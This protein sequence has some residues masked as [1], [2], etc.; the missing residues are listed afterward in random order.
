MIR[1]G[2]AGVPINCNSGSTLDGIR[3]CKELGLNAMELE[4]VHGVRMKDEKAKEAKKISEELDI[5]LSSHAPYYINCCTTD[6]RKR[7]NSFRHIFS[8][9]KTTYLAGGKITVFHPG[10]Y[11]KLTKEEAYENAKKLLQE[12]E[13]KCKQ[14]NVKIRLGAETVGKKSAFGGLE[15][16]VRLSQDIEM[17][18]VV[19]DFSHLVARG[20]YKLENEDDYRKVFEYVERELPGYG[21]RIHA[22]FSEINFTEKGERNHLILG[23]NNTPPFK[24]LMK[25]L[26]EGG[27]S[28]TIICETP[29]IDEDALL[30]KGEYEKIVNRLS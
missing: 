17:V 25:V 18:D 5:S 28:G 27:Y 7:A 9:A 19:I 10:F 21:K 2:P 16:N 26:A 22:H 23:S 29:K 24:P 20:D 4:F 3:C 15:E 12:I 1:F 11:M 30:L 8:A 13:E 14:E 6:E